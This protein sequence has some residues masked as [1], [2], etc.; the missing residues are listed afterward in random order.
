MLRGGSGGGCVER[1]F[2]S[3]GDREGGRGVPAK[4]TGLKR[5]KYLSF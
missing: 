1:W 2:S 3:L 4:V 5:L